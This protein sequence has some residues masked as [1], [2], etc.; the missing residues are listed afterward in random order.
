M[1]DLQKVYFQLYFKFTVI[2][3]VGLIQTQW[4]NPCPHVLQYTNCQAFLQIAYA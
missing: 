3:I 1:E 2:K 4:L